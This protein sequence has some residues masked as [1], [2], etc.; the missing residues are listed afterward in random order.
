MLMA[1]AMIQTGFSQS[2]PI[3]LTAGKDTVSS[4][5]T[6]CIPVTV[7]EFTDII[8]FQHSITWNPE[9]LTFSN[10]QNLGLTGLSVPNSFNQTM[11]GRL[12]VGWSSG[13]TEG[14]SL[15]DQTI[16]FEVCFNAIGADNTYSHIHIGGEGFPPSAGGAEAYNENMVNV[17]G[18]ESG[19]AG[20]VAISN[21]VAVQSPKEEDT[22]LR[23][24]PNPTEGSVSACFF[25]QQDGRVILSVTDLMGR[26]LFENEK[27]EQAGNVCETLTLPS[28]LSAGNY[29]MIVQTADGH[30]ASETLSVQR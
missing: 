12:L 30:L 14:V 19:I 27:W 24:F 2:Q 8:D 26:V 22:T 20:L 21:S 4:G 6:V 3:V 17:W 15:N 11:P 13:T 7:D 9:V 29:L 5:S 25:Q 1:V 10:I 28:H 23:V 16:L 18:A